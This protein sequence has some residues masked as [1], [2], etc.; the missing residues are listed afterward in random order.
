[1]TRLP[2]DREELYQAWFWQHLEGEQD[3]LGVSGRGVL[4]VSGRGFHQ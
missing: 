3:M 2:E 4:L 1:M